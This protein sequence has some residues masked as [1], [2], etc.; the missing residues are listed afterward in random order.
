MGGFPV[1]NRSWAA[2]VAAQE[3]EKTR[4]G[5][6]LYIRHWVCERRETARRTGDRSADNVPPGRGGV[7]REGT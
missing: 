7:K 2:R 6:F 5:A 1:V 3:A 4:P